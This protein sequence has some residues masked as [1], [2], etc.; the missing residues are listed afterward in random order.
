MS[1]SASRRTREIG[2]R[3]ALGAARSQVLGMMVRDG[4]RLAAIGIAIG[5]LLSVAA[6]RLIAGWL[7]DVSPLDGVDVRRHGR[8]LRRRGLRR[9]LSAGASRRRAGS[10][11]G[12]AGG[13]GPLEG[14]D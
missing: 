11:V 2:I 7:F 14:R 1:F 4:M 10:A 8:A 5:L 3:V 9:E 13:L 12:A 6:T